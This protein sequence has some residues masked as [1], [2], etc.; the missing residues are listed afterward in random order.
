MIV[1]AQ[2]VDSE[3]LGIDMIYDFLLDW[4]PLKDVIDPTM[5]PASGG[6]LWLRDL[7]HHAIRAPGMHIRTNK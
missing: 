5:Q 7:F 4:N 6:G 3:L 1:V 2:Y